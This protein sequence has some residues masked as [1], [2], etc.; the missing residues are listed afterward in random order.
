MRL[1]FSQSFYLTFIYLSKDVVSFFQELCPLHS[2]LFSR[3]SI[4]QHVSYASLTKFQNKPTTFIKT[5]KELNTATVFHQIIL[6]FELN[7]I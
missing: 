3:F 4:L 1:T 6:L 5:S 7:E 2:L